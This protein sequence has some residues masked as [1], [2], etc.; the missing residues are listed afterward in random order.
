MRR[1]DFKN[2]SYEFEDGT[3]VRLRTIGAAHL[4]AYTNRYKDTHPAPVPPTYTMQ[5]G[6]DTNDENDKR[7]Q[8]L[9]NEWNERMGYDTLLFLIDKG[10]LDIPPSDYIPINDDLPVKQDWILGYLYTAD[11]MINFQEAVMGLSVPTE[12]GIADAEKN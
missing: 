3:T 1:G 7:Y 5:N 12:A 11:L 8:F 9:L 10:V 6:E 4:M 2:P